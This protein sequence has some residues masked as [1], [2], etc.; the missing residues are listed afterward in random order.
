MSNG[1][2]KAARG[3]VMHLGAQMT[4]MVCGYAVSLV[5]ARTLGPA[6]FG[7]YGVVYSFLVAAELIARLG[8]PQA[9][10]KLVAERKGPAPLLEATSVTVSGM[11]YLVL[12]AA[13]WLAAPALSALFNIEDGTRLFRI[14]SL[15]IP[16]YGLYAT[17]FHILNG[18]RRF[19]QES[20]S[21]TLYGLM[22][23]VGIAI[24]VAIGP[25][26]ESALILNVLVSVGALVFCALALG[27]G[28]FRLTLAEAPPILRLA[29]PIG[30][31]T[32]GAQMLPS[33][34]LWVLSIVGTHQGAAE[35][36]FYVAAVNVARMPNFLANALASVLLPSIAQAI[37]HDDEAL[38]RRTFDGAMRFLAIVLIPGCV[39]IAINAGA[40]MALLFSADYAAGGPVLAVLI[41]AQGLCLTVFLTL[42]AVLVGAGRSSFAGLLAL[43]VLPPGIVLDAVLASAFGVMGAAVGALVTT[44]VAMIAAA[45]ALRRRLGSLVRPGVLLRVL[46]AT[47]LAGAVSW[48]LQGEGPLVVVEL[49]GVGV[50]YLELLQL[51]GL[52]RLDDLAP[53]LP[54]RLRPQQS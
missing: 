36:G 21:L 27:R 19:M 46:A 51:Y 43:A 49:L 42:C 45:A 2:T 6:E 50:G 4:L 30:V 53:F 34:D 32:L 18:R 11:V 35:M 17:L 10:A 7:V 16:F 1:T 15:D 44:A 9:A 14:A 29:L 5:L 47:A 24:L 52:V 37:A 22:K 23:G 25:T 40:I 8:I 20:L 12:F 39:L 13:F 41:F 38:A 3:T 54:A 33:I 26:V 31:M 48:Y 28:P